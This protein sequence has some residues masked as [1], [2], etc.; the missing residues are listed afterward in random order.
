MKLVI[1]IFAI[2]F[3]MCFTAGAD[4]QSAP[5]VKPE[6]AVAGAFR[7]TLLMIAMLK[8]DPINILDLDETTAGIVMDNI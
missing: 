7:F 8:S 6:V 2:S 1:T 5:A 4:Y 3:I